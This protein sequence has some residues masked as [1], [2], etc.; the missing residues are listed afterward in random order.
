MAGRD[1]GGLGEDLVLHVRDGTNHAHQPMPLNGDPV[2][3]DLDNFKGRCMLL[4][5][6]QSSYDNA[7]AEDNYPYKKHFHGRKRLWEWRLQGRFKRRPGVLYCGV[8]LEEY[9]P[10]SFATRTLM[11][12]ILPLIQGALQCKLVRHEV[13]RP[14]D[15]TLRPVVVAPIWAADN[16]LVHRD[17]ADAPDL[18]CSTLPTGLSRKA[19]RQYW[20]S[21][22]AGGASAWDDGGEGPTFT[23]AVWG[24]SQLL[25]LRAWVFRKL[26][27]MWGRDIS[28]EPFCGQQPVHAV[29]YELEDSDRCD[30]HRQGQKIY[31][32]DVRM[33]PESVWMAHSV[34]LRSEADERAFAARISQHIAEED[35]AFDS[36]HRGNSSESF[37]SAVSQCSSLDRGSDE[38]LLP[39]N[40]GS[41]D[42]EDSVDSPMAQ[43]PVPLVGTSS[44]ERP[45]R[46]GICMLF[47]FGCCKRRRRRPVWEH[48]V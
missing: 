2:E 20:E 8:E 45:A 47:G 12:G 38:K 17:P 40:D 30:E 9:V 27:L 43:L 34:G 26:P 41:H 32:V 7:D 28:L 15:S 24:P 46:S 11:R 44:N 31:A 29:I 18:T 1:A 14:D 37:C 25:D 13:G 35:V 16:T 21:V 23:F 5:R 19:A 42:P 22:W 4:H 39:P 6:P 33:M 36:M 10:V 48:I 3:F